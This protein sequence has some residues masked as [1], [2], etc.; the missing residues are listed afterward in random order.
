MVNSV[1]LQYAQA[2]FDLAKESKCASDYYQAL[3]AINAVI[4]EEEI[5]KTFSHPNINLA[6]KKEILANALG[7]I[8]DETLL[9]FVF[10]LLDNNRLGDLSLIVEAYKELLN[11]YENVIEVN[12]Y[13]KYPL[14]E[15][16][17]VDLHNKLCSYYQKQVTIKEEL[18]SDLIGGVKITSAGKI[19]D[20]STLSALDNLKNSLKKGY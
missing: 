8:V 9:H 18:D 17:R 14:S 1:G 19:I 15:E 20:L 13:S 5:A 11:E 10:V 3:N 16:Q 2:I 12:V 7:E 4:K 6:T